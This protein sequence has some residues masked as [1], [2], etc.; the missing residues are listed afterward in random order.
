MAAETSSADAEFSSLMAAID[1]TA[2][3]TVEAALVMRVAASLVWL[4]MVAMASEAATTPDEA[5]FMEATAA[6]IR[7]TARLVA[8]TAVSMA[9]SESPA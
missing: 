7:S 9:S 2:P 3:E 5:L 4:A 1:W 8:D 6:V